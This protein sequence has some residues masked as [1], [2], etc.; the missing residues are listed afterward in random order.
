MKAEVQAEL[1]GKIVED[2]PQLTINHQEVLETGL[3]K[4]EIMRTIVERLIQKIP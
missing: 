4:A 3:K 2:P 1:E